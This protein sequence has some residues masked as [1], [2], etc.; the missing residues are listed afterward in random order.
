MSLLLVSIAKNSLAII[1]K[2]ALSITQLTFAC[3]IN[4]KGKESIVVGRCIIETQIN[5]FLSR[6]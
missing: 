6:K 5:T 3:F 1:L 4:K 2:L